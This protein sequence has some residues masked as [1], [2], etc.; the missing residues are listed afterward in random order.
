MDPNTP[1]NLRLYSARGWQE[2]DFSKNN[3]NNNNQ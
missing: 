1:P 3:N 2:A